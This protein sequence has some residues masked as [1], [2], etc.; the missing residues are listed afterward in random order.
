MTSSL[1]ERRVLLITTVIGIILSGLSPKDRLTW[2]LEIAPVLIGIP[3]LVASHSRFSPTPLIYRLLAGHAVVLMI[4]AHYTYAEVPLGRWAQDAFGLAR[5]HY[6]RLGHFAQGFVPAI[7]ARELLL[8]T[9]PLQRGRWLFFLVCSV[10][11]AFS[12]S[13]E[14]FEWGTA[15]VLGQSAD[16][17]LATQGD[18]WDTQW[19]MFLALLGSVIAQGCLAGIHDRQL[20]ALHSRAFQ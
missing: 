9:S 7:L 13:Y 1:T 20:A 8:R 12:A 3:I 15:H 2:F 11:L 4:G 19:D 16:D 5:N 10:C 6:D 18:E 14:L 17:F